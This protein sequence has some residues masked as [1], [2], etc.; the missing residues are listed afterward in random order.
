MAVDNA[1]AA[2]GGGDN[3]DDDDDVVYDKKAKNVMGD[4]DGEGVCHA[5]IKF[6]RLCDGP[7]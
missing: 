4:E 2:G 7:T 1:G 6:D 5:A 3:D